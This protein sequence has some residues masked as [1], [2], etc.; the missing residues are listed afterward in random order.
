MQLMQGSLG[1]LMKPVSTAKRNSRLCTGVLL[2]LG[3]VERLGPNANATVCSS[4]LFAWA[5]RFLHPG[6]VNRQPP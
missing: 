6:R 2:L 4:A 3:A 5:A 1:L